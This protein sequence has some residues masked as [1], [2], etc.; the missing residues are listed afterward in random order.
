MFV[1]YN[2]RDM[3]VTQN[4]RD[5]LHSTNGSWIFAVSVLA[6]PPVNVKTTGEKNGKRLQT[7]ESEAIARLKSLRLLI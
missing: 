6:Q 1:E 5:R 7:Q 2:Y 3:P 4:K